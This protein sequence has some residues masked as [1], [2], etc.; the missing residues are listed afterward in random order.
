MSPPDAPQR[1]G[2]LTPLNEVLAA[3]ARLARPVAARALPLDLACGRVLAADMASQMA[4]AGR[5]VALRDGWAVRADLVADAGPYMP[6]PVSTTWVEAGDAM[7]DDTD[8][9]LRPDAVQQSGEAREAVASAQPGDGVLRS[10]P[11]GEE[12][13][14]QAGTMLR[15]LDIAALRGAGI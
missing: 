3:L 11:G 8:A 4:S 14:A 10:L 13:L 12:P 6:V 7:P 1:I 15:A 9:V 5:A 2:R